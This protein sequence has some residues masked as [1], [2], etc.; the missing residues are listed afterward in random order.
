MEKGRESGTSPAAYPTCVIRR[1]GEAFE[2][3]SFHCSLLA[4]SPEEEYNLKHSPTYLH[5]G[6]TLTVQRLLTFFKRLAAHSFQSLHHRFVAW[7]KPDTTSLLL[8]TLTDLARSKS[9]LVAE[10]AFLRQPLIILRRQVKRPACTKTD[11]MLLVLLASMV[12]TW[13]QAL[14]IVQPETL[15][16]WHRLGFQL[17]WKYKSRAASLKL[18][19]SQEAVA[20]IKQMARDNQLW[21]AERIRGEL[22]KLGMHVS[23]RTIQKYMR[24][25][26][27]PRPRGQTW[28]TFLHTHA[29]DMWACDFL[30]VTDLFF[31]SLFAFFIIDIHTRQVIHVG[32]TRS[33][34][35]AWTAQQLRE[36][37]PYEQA[38]KYLIR[39]RDCKFG[40]SFARVATT[41][42]I[43]ILKTPYHA[44]QA[45][46]ICER[47]LG[48][49]RRE[50][51]DH[52]FL[53]QEKQLQRVLNAYVNYFNQ[54]RPHQGIQQQ[55][56]E[57]KA[58]CLPAHQASGKV[59]TFPVLGGLHH[60]YRRSA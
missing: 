29:K 48:S 21:G 13:K 52:L 41:S 5:R 32:V 44:P 23:K 31:R 19:I 47:F 15:L 57:Q 46:A 7:T 42:G 8:G 58:G 4:D 18:R 24:H 56:P 11:R 59:L 3:S 54:A 43:K 38:P 25:A 17:F 60:D 53:L 6:G 39:D 2:T 1:L 27:S 33:P 37:A 51:L 10:N 45:N 36:A 55:I 35:D 50:C 20:L 34:T 12:R 49:V 40:P 28:A 26:R 9:E 22:L 30:Q 16:R 14:L